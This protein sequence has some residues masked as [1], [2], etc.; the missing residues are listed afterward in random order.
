MFGSL[1][2]ACPTD[3]SR[4]VHLTRYNRGLKYQTNLGKIVC[5]NIHNTLGIKL[6]VTILGGRGPESYHSSPISVVATSVLLAQQMAKTSRPHTD[7]AS[8]AA[9]QSSVVSRRVLS[10]AAVLHQKSSQLISAQENAQSEVKGQEHPSQASGDRQ[11][12]SGS[13]RHPEVK[14]SNA[15]DVEGYHWMPKK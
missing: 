4:Q 6:T 13:T 9:S 12:V 3:C 14:E 2:S 5:G 11:H 8:G 15:S 10:Q 1:R 7:E